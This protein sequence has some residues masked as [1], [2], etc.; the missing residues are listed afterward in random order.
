MN[1]QEFQELAQFVIDH[2]NAP[3]SLFIGGTSDWKARAHLAHFL[4]MP[5]LKKREVAIELFKSVVDEKIDLE[6]PEEVEEKAY[7]LQ[8]LSTIMKE[9]KK[10][11]DALY[12]IN[13]A[14]E[15]IESTDFVYKHL[16]RGEIWADRWNVLF[17]LNRVSDAQKEI[18]E[19][20]IAFGNLKNISNS[21][22][23]YGY[24]FKAQVYATE[25][26]KDEAITNM[27]MAL[28]YMNLPE[29]Y[30]EKVEDAL[31]AEHNNIP[32]ILNSTDHMCPPPDSIPWDI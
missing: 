29:E 20:I 8:R 31:K 14:I 21:Y 22:L 5:E 10:Y 28:S 6:N 25:G 12:Y 2:T 30:K 26:L 1:T 3:S 9:E 11:K 23:Y 32:W 16:L 18:D 7:A 27:K 17:Y 19:K 13:L 24:R 4:A 15:T